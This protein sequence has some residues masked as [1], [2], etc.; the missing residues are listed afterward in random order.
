[1]TATHTFNLIHST[2][3]FIDVKISHIT[4]FNIHVRTRRKLLKNVYV[5]LYFFLRNRKFIAIAIGSI[6]SL[7]YALT[8]YQF[9]TN[10]AMIHALYCIVPSVHYIV[11]PYF[12]STVLTHTAPTVSAAG[13]SA[14]SS[15]SSATIPVGKELILG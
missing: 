14:I 15:G 4:H 8:I 7:L 5:L 11:Q 3:Q 13:K 12:E 2:I 1:M 9:Y 10:F 6:G